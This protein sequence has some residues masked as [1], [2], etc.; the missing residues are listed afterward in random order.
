MTVDDLSEQTLARLLELIRINADAKIGLEEAVDELDSP[1]LKSI[2]IDLA[3]KREANA[4]ELLR[5][6]HLNQ[7]SANLTGSYLGALHRCWMK[8]RTVC[9]KNDR[10]AILKEAEFGEEHI[11]KA[12]EAALKETA[13][14]PINDV[15]QRQYSKVLEAR[16]YI[17]DLCD[18]LAS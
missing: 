4:R 16:D 5:Y 14:S 6:V 17:H 3:G 1:D 7:G 10:H 9:S 13:G 2:F 8:L 11:V 18:A 15:L 12:Y